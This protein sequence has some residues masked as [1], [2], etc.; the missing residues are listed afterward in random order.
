MVSPLPTLSPDDL[1]A[2]RER[3]DVVDGELHRLLR[4]R[5][6]IVESI[7]AT[8]G[9]AA[10]IIRPDRE[11]EVIAN[12]L[13]QHEG[14]M[15][16]DTLV[17]FWR[18][19]IGGACA[20]QRPFTVH[21][22]GTLD[23]ARFLY[24]PVAMDEAASPAAAVAALADA[25][26]DVAVVPDDG[27]WWTE[28]GPAHVFGRIALSNGTHVTVL[29]GTRVGTSNGPMALTVE[30]DTLTERPADALTDDALLLGRFTPSPFTIPVAK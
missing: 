7:G 29:G 18:V 8:K 27:R 30:D 9:P 21:V 11:V 5:F 28:R 16:A 1:T 6:A 20:V 22:A 26:D 23:A 24:G 2:L 13:A 10:P 17:H 12:R 14:A 15:P 19:L 3:L 4:E 25:P